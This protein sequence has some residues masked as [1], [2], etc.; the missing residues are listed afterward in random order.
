MVQPRGPERSPRLTV[1][2]RRQAARGTRERRE[3]P[4]TN[5]RLQVNKIAARRAG[6]P[7]G[8]SRRRRE[9]E[10]PRAKRILE[11]IPVDR[12]A[13]AEEHLSASLTLTAPTHLQQTPAGISSSE[14]AGAAVTC[15]PSTAGG[16]TPTTWAGPPASP[17]LLPSVLQPCDRLGAATSGLSSLPPTPHILPHRTPGGVSDRGSHREPAPPWGGGAPWSLLPERQRPG[18]LPWAS[19]CS[20]RAWPRTVV[21][22]AARVTAASCWGHH[23]PSG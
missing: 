4:A 8:S 18:R 9:Q 22:D 6:G 21:S 12:T 7:T 2:T 3:G 10:V 16:H 15:P 1:A 20:E 11:T 23:G 5:R 17:P 19:L 14:A 13:G